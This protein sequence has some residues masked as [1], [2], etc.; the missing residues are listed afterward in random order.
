MSDIAVLRTVHERDHVYSA[1][2]IWCPACD[3][4]HMLAVDGDVPP[5]KPRWSFDGNLAAPTLSP[6]I[7]TRS[8]GY[9]K[10][11]EPAPGEKQEPGDQVCHS[12]LR[13]GVWAFLDDCTHAFA[14]Q[15]VPSPP[16]P[17][18]VDR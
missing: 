12:F 18:W 1:I 7:L 5:G 3:D 17:E 8:Y 9:P 10:G 6:S 14:G 13:D 15:R 2:L 11:I 16:L 4:L